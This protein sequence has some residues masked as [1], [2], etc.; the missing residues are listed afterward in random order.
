MSRVLLLSLGEGDVISRCQSA[1]VG[2]SAIEHLPAGG[3]RLVCMS[4]DGATVMRKKFKSE[5]IAG[6]VV[7]SLYRPRTPPL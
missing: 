1:K 2:I 7:R 6:P 4:S 3:T 5:L